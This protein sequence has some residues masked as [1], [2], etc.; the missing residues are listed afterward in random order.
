MAIKNPLPVLLLSCTIAGV[1]PAAASERVVATFKPVHSLVSAVMAGVGEPYLIMRGTATPHTYRMRLSDARVIGRARVIFIIGEAVE[2]TLAGPIRKLG[3]KAR[4]VKLVDVPGLVRMPL[5]KGGAFEGDG[6]DHG[7][8]HGHGH[9]DE[10]FDMHVWLDPVNAGLMALVIGRHLSE[11]DPA[12]AGKYRANADAVIA[13]LDE[14]T[15]KLDTELAP[16]RG[17]PFIVFQDAYQY[18]EKRFELEAVGSA[19]VSTSRL[20]G[21]R[22]VREL[23]K[24]VGDLGVVCVFAGPRYDP[25]FVKLITEGT[26]AR[27]GTVDPVGTAIK[28]GPGMYSAL[29]R[30]MAASF[31]KC[32]APSG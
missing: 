30:D 22:R 32:L 16:A 14:V 13:G 9:Q 12:N 1:A 26:K 6:R 17:K 4:V 25:R 7:H 19:V 11:V 23:R 28:P 5:R 27:A 20:P 10:A 29:M 15:A 3:G 31:K 24:K 8:G 18:F 21:V 2:N